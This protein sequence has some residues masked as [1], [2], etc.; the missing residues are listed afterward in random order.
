MESKNKKQKKRQ[1]WITLTPAMCET[2]R[3][4]PSLSGNSQAQFQ[5]NTATATNNN[6]IW[7]RQTQHTPVQRPGPQQSHINASQQPQQHIPSNQHPGSPSHEN[8]MFMGSSHLQGSLD[9]YR[10]AGGQGQQIPGGMRQPPGQS[11]DEFPPLGRNGTDGND[12]DRGFGAFGAPSAF[13]SQHDGSARPTLPAGFG[14]PPEST[15]SSSAQMLTSWIFSASNNRSPADP[16]RPLGLGQGQGQNP[17]N[18]LTS[19]LSN[20][21]SNSQ[22]ATASNSNQQHHSDFEPPLPSTG[23]IPASQKPEDMSEAD[24]YGL[25]GFLARIRSEDPMVAG[26]AR[27]QDL[28]QL[29]LNLSSPDPLYPTWS[30][31]FADPG[32]RPLQPD[33]TLPECYTVGNVHRVRDKLPGFSDE[34]LFWIFYTQPQD[35]LQELAAGE[36]TNRN[37]RYHKHHQMWLT[38]DSTLPEPRRVSDDEELGSYVFFNQRGWEKMR[39]SNS[40]FARSLSLAITFLIL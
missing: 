14:N 32:A 10:Q 28:T 37:W 25:A 22:R 26:L 20:F 19:L 9:D 39:V 2:N 34:T 35:I 29:G 21:S 31:P 13:S 36:L 27:G 33:F 5:N 3:E 8:D 11:I 24:R 6:P 1:K 7:Q 12:N 16:S 40:L 30:G 4:F 23:D 17:T 38:K 15:R 18:N